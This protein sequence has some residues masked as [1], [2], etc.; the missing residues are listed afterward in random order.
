MVK[1]RERGKR[2]LDHSVSEGSERRPGQAGSQQTGKLIDGKFL[3]R[4]CLQAAMLLCPSRPKCLHDEESR[5]DALVLEQ[6][7]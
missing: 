4:N 6:D 5:N 2:P 7:D 3:R 1:R